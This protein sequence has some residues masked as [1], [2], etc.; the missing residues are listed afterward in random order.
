MFQD[1]DDKTS[2]STAVTKLPSFKAMTEFAL[3]DEQVKVQFAEER[4]EQAEIEFTE[5]DWEGQLE[6]DK[7]GAVKNT[8]R[9]L[10]LI[11]EHD[12]N[13][14]GIVFN[15]LSDNL[16]IVSPVPWSHPSKYWRDA[17]DAQLVSY[18]DTHYGTFSARNYDIAIA[19]VADDR[20]YHPIRDYLDEL[21][22][23]D[24][25]PRVDT[26]LIDYLGA[27]DNPYVRAVT[28]KTLCAAISRV[29]TPGIKFD[30]MLVLNGP[31]GV[32]KVRLL[33]GLVVS[34]FQIV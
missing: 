2:Y 6:L 7:T 34:G 33:Q 10:T 18:V 17:D 32:G 12:E 11:L 30:S 5:D 15:E 28:R 9:N 21:P 13:L 3:K 25:V 1:L 4:K 16:E 14:Q 27:D 20:S 31:Q 23:W 24:K 8:L 26:L 19:K 22:E 29:L